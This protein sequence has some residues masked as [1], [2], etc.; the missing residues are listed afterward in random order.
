MRR[1]AISKTRQA[2]AAG[3]AATEIV[4]A[5]GRYPGAGEGTTGFFASLALEQDLPR[6]VPHQRWDLEQYYSPEARGDLTMYTRAAAF[7]DDLDMFDAGLFRC[8]AKPPLLISR[9]L[10]L[11]VTCLVLVLQVSRQFIATHRPTSSL[12]SFM[13]CPSVG[14]RAER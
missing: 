3:A 12:G 11:F 13:S 9:P 2:E 7:L 10:T 4:G 8:P 1:G 14:V 5:A 6:H